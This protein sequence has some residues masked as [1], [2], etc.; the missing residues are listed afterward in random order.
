MD[1]YPY[2]RSIPITARPD[3]LVAGGG[4]AGICASVSAA[5][6]DMNVLLV[7]QFADLG[8]A[9]TISGV[10]GFC[11]HT[12]GVGRP[13][14]EIVARLADAEAVAPY[15]PEQDGRAI[16]SAHAAY[17][18]TDYV[19]SQGI[20]VL[21]HAQVI[22]ALRDRDRIDAL[23]IHTSGG[24]EAVRPKIVIDAT[25]DADLVHAAG[26]PTESGT[27]EDPESRLPMS[28]C[29]SMWDTHEKQK[30]WLPDGCPRYTAE[31]IPMTSVS[32]RSGGRIDVKMKVIKHSAV[33]GRELSAAEIEARRQMMGLVHFLQTVGYGGK[34]YDTYRL[35]SVAPHI[36]VREGRRII[37]EVRLTTDDV[38]NGRRWPDAVGVGTYHIDYHWP[39]IL[40]RAGTGITDPVPTYH[41]P[42]RMLIPKGSRDLLVAGRCA[43][44]DQLAMSSFRVMATAAAMGH[45]A[46][47]CAAMAVKDGI[48]PGEV[49]GAA[50][51]AALTSSGAVLEP[52]W[53][54][55][56]RA[57]RR[58]RA[59]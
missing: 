35:S 4:L 42:L 34:L 22:D 31:T 21:L 54:A 52:E 56:Y 37:G 58:E 16:E 43:S 44:G 39:D 57:G 7:E 33:N 50:L 48:S 18:M 45:A 14:D 25:G 51:Q 17:V 30:P 40:Q 12:A 13:F 11:G 28:L 29:F 46:G 49:D 27:D 23:V 15:S 19:V 8:G 26:F 10:S 32:K 53:H 3:V 6:A 5:H 1:T 36:G 38:R 41:L 20:E 24:L 59:G 55:V 9:A 2:S 47:R